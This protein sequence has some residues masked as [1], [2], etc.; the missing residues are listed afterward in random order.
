MAARAALALVALMALA[1]GA[2]A[3]YTIDGGFGCKYVSPAKATQLMLL[4]T[5][6]ITPAAIQTQLTALALTNNM[7]CKSCDT[8]RMQEANAADVDVWAS[9]YLQCFCA[10]DYGW[11][12]SCT[13]NDG[14][15]TCKNKYGCNKCPDA[16]TSNPA[17]GPYRTGSNRPGTLNRWTGTPCSGNVNP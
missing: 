10:V 14:V 5:P 11:V 2:Q 7:I 6:A 15:S 8:K 9:G 16:G 1:Y 4:A 17:L 13:T 12:Q 3:T